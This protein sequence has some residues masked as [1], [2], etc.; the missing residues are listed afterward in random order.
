MNF[1]IYETKI[2]EEFELVLKRMHN[3]FIKLRTGRATPAILDGILV[4]YYGSMTPINQLAN[5]SVPEP[6]VLAIKPYDRSSIKDVASAINASNLGVN[7]Q[8][9]VDIIRLTFAAPT[10][11]VRKN[12]AKKA[13]QVGEEAK[14]RVRHIR[15][16]AQDLFKKDSS[17]VEDDKKFFQ[18]ELDNL[19]KELNKEIEAVVSHKEK[20]IMTV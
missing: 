9:D 15:Q 5:I 7:P 13:K 1:K 3:E 8:V 19:T 16:E 10:E 20:D 18:T 11:E 6:R 14:I 12:L 17:T 4:D 2:R